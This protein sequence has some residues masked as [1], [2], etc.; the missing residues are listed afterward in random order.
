MKL[1][2][3]FVAF[4][5]TVFVSVYYVKKHEQDAGPNRQ[6]LKIKNTI[7]AFNSLHRPVNNASKAYFDQRN[8]VGDFSQQVPVFLA[9]ALF[10]GTWTAQPGTPANL[11]NGFLNREGV[12]EMIYV[13]DTDT[14]ITKVI[15][16][17]QDQVRFASSEIH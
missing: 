14:N 10:A 17:L 13:V 8:S 11:F 5:S 6:K 15:L 3:G 12:A 7:S 16:Q 9:D 2:L 4:L 1:L